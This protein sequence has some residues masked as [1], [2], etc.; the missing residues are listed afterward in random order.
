[1]TTRTDR[2]TVTF[3]QPFHLDGIDGLQPPGAYL[4]DTDEETI[5]EL[6]FIAWRRIATMI[7]IRRNGTDQV[8]RIDPVELDAGLMRDSGKTVMPMGEG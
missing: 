1:M 2:R 8:F 5:D 3:T 6:S 7:H 4:V